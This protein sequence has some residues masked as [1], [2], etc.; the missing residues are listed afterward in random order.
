M[1]L[2]G[3]AAGL[4][5]ATALAAAC[6]ENTVTT[7]RTV[8]A[9][10][11]AAC[12]VDGRG[13]ATY[14]ALGDY[15]EAPPQTGHLLSAVGTSLPEIDTNARQ[16]V[17]SATES[18]GTWEG[19]APMPSSGDVNVLVLPHLSPCALSGQVG[20]RTGSTLAPIGSTRV[21]IVGGSASPVPPTYV[22]DLT[23]GAVT[24]A[25]PELRPPRLGATVTPFGDGAVVAG[26]TSESGIIQ[27]TALV[28]SPALGGF[29]LAHAITLSEPR[30]HHAAVALA[31]G[32]TLLVGGSG[33]AG[34]S[35]LLDT[36]DVIDPTTS[37]AQEEGFALLVT[38]RLDPV[39]VRL[40]SGEILVAGGTDAIGTPVTTMEW[41]S[42]EAGTNE[43]QKPQ[44]WG[45]APFTMTALEGGGALVVE[46]R[47]QSTWVVGAAGDIKQ[48]T[49]TL[50]M[51]PNPVLFGGA[52][53]AP[54]L[55][56]GDRFLRWQPWSATWGEFVTLDGATASVQ[57]TI[58]SPDPGLAMW[59]DANARQLVAMRFDTRNAY[60]ELLPGGAVDLANDTS[61]DELPSPTLVSFAPGT[62]I[63]VTSDANAFVTD[64]TYEDVTVH[65]T[66]ESSP[67]ACVV[68]RT[69]SGQEVLLPD[70][71]ITPGN[72][73]DV[74]RT[75]ATVS[76]SIDG[77]AWQTSQSNI[78]VG[79]RV[80]V[81]VRGFPGS[82]GATV[83]G[84]RISRPGTP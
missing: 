20:T 27:S 71:K 73:L 49:A 50:G 36:L 39:V 14:V 52:G 54:V 55:W 61:P 77:R 43:L 5:L 69:T 79:N 1:A 15:D 21:M 40:A 53:G 76:F 4:A 8:T 41:I 32:R 45:D 78:A 58:V 56:T 67:G 48:S 30:A 72:V 46:N 23:T 42:F 47:N 17:V 28:Y 62:G 2:A 25:N 65:V 3:Q 83:T 24:K 29:D 31:D 81:G 60:S 33:T 34:G 84:I 59:F 80:S 11:P 37:S 68:L 75:G 18:V 57:G 9:W 6:H 7:T 64:R 82:S 51:L 66:S 35:Q 13:Y 63:A 26:G 44:P 19:L 10:V 12:P 16:L 70:P 22:A 38:P 74:R